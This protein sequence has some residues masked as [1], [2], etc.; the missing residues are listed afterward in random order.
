MYLDYVHRRSCDAR[1]SVASPQIREEI[2]QAFLAIGC[3]FMTPHDNDGDLVRYYLP[4]LYSHNTIMRV[5]R[6]GCLGYCYNYGLKFVYYVEISN[7]YNP[8]VEPF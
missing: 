8:N 3:D 2:T 7:S 4:F 1:V 5:C 6:L